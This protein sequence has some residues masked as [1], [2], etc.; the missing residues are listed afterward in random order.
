MVRL[1]DAAHPFQVVAQIGQ[2]FFG[3]VEF[4]DQLRELVVNVRQLLL[5]DLDD[6]DLDLGV[7]AAIRPTHQGGGEPLRLT[8]LHAGQCLVQAVEHTAGA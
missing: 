7:L 6:L 2:H 4:A 3:A 8:S 5:L 1:V